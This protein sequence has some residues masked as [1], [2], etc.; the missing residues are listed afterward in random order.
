MTTFNDVLNA[1]RAQ[2]RTTREQG[3]L[4]E[5]LMVAI[6]PQMPD[7]GF[8]SVWTWKDWPDREATTGMNAQDIG[9]D[10][11]GKRRDESGYC[12]IQCKFYDPE[13]QIR[14]EDLGT[15]FTMSGK[16]AFS[17]RMIVATS[18][19]WTK[20]AE[21]AIRHQEPPVSRMRF[22]DLEGLAIDW[23][24]FEPKLTTINIEKYPLKARQKEALEAVIEGFK[25]K[26][27]GKLIMAC[28]T[29][30]TLTSL[31]IAETMIAEAMIESSGHVLFLVPSISLLAQSLHEWSFQR[32]MDHRYIAVCSDTRVDKTSEDSAIEDLI[33]PPSTKAA[34]VA[35]ALSQKANRMTVVFCT[36]QSI[37]VIHRAQK[38]G[39]PDFDLVICDEAHRT[40]GIDRGNFE[41][42]KTSPFVR[43]H[44]ADYLKA[45][46]RLYM[47][48]TP[49]IY[50]DHS[51]QKAS[52]NSVGIYS[53]D[54][55]A[56][57]GPVFYRLSFSDAI[58]EG[59]LSDY[60]VVVL[61]MSEEHV[62]RDMQEIMSRENELTVDDV[63]K[64]VGCYNAL[65][66]RPEETDS[67]K[68]KRVVSFSNTI[69][70]SKRIR[71]YFRTVVDALDEKENDGFTCQT[72]HV[73][74]KNTALERKQKLDWLR[75]P[76]GANEHGE[77]CRILSNARCLTE[78]VDVPSLD[79]AI[80]MNPRKSQVDVVQ[81]VG[82][83]MRKAEGKD[84]GYV[85]LPIVIKAGMTPEDALD[86]NETYAVVWEIL[87]AL[88]SHDDRLPNLI[89]K[90][91]LNMN[92]P[93]FLQVIGGN[94]WDAGDT[95]KV[96]RE[97]QLQLHFDDELRNAIYAKIV[98]KVGDRQ[99][100]ET[101]AKDVARI[102]DLLVQRITDLVAAHVLLAEVLADF[103]A[104]LHA[105]VNE[106]ITKED[107]ISMI[108]Q[109]IITEPI[110]DALFDRHSFS[111]YHGMAS[112]LGHIIS[113]FDEY[114]LTNE[115][116]SMERFYQSV[117]QNVSGIDNPA[118]R[119]KV[120]IELYE[121]FFKT[122]FP[123]ESESLGI[124]YTP[125]EIVDFILHSANHVLK[126][127][128]GCGIGDENVHVIDPFTGTGTFVNRLISNPDLIP[129][130]RL[131][132]KYAHEIHANEVLLMAYYIASVNIEMAYHARLCDMDADDGYTSFPGIV[133][134][135][136]FQLYERKAT[137]QDDI[138]D[139]FMIENNDRRIRQL[140][141][142]IRVIVGNPPY[143]AG[144]K[145]ENDA[146]K[147]LSY[148]NLDD[149]IR[150]TY[151]A[152]STSTLKNALYDSYIRAFKWASNRIGDEG[153]IAF[154]SGAAWI[155]RVFADGM[156]ACLA[157]EFSAIHVLHLRG[158]I[159]KNML[160]KGLAK[161]GQNVFGQ[162]SMT[163]IAITI[164]V[165]KPDATSRGK[166]F[167]HDIGDDLRRDEKLARIAAAQSIADLDWTAI[168]PDVHG[169]WLNQRNPAFQGFMALGRDEVKR[170]KV[171]SPDTV[172]R[173]YSG[174][175][176]T[177]R[178]A[179]AYNF[180][181]AKVADK[182]AAMI[183]FY[184]Q[185][186]AA[187]HAAK[188]TTPAI[189]ID[190]FI[191]SDST[192]ISWDG[193]LKSDLTKGHVGI[194]QEDKIISSIYRP[195]FKAPLY[196]DRQ[197]NNSVY[198][199]PSIFPTVD[200]QNR[201][202]AVTGV[203]SRSG[204]S[205][206]MTDYLPCSDFV[207]KSQ[208]FP[209]WIFDE[210]GDNRQDNIPAEAVYRFQDHYDDC[211]ITADRLFD[212]FYGV[213]HA[214]DYRAK[215]TNDLVKELPR[216]PFARDFWTFAD[217]GSQLANL[218]LNYMTGPPAEMGI[219]LDGAAV[220]PDMI[221]EHHYQ[222]TKMRWLDR[223]DGRF[224][225]YNER[226][227]V[228]PIPPEALRYVVSGKSALDWVIDRYCV[229]IDK[230]SGIVN[231]V[232]D[233]I[234]EQGEPDALIKLI[235]RITWLSVQTVKIVDHLPPALGDG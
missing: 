97:V 90:L 131:V 223:G 204:F 98:E 32:R 149:S 107:A 181:R 141:A 37:D 218:H 53:M 105:D 152:R 94:A 68:L 224:I 200:T 117:R 144:Q 50:T 89:S 134:T 219:L 202:I 197:F 150:A 119:Q 228:G 139:R 128:F 140:E 201:V 185:Q 104:S 199:M 86:D 49:R 161:E 17:S 178:D 214:P 158:D 69:N 62:S 60:R 26:D 66:N 38:M 136:T 39:A 162:A 190:D 121:K 81:A 15:F 173:I 133:L 88:R 171:V 207:E 146:N 3:T 177:N 99:Y 151:A 221:E 187:F 163:G 40:T 227:S 195:F 20:H 101:W 172:F 130:D 103:L 191:D 4:F 28:G 231:D 14:A 118:A 206:L 120:V 27:R 42:G 83:V 169:D 13:T 47:T 213:L 70:N 188:A 100:W 55:E 135:D 29:G 198:R 182:M 52:D 56:E 72:D 216:I 211:S 229:K 44:D 85:I 87:R 222:V 43:V 226:L 189:K 21:T 35:S 41:K 79:A 65:R 138:V 57:Y 175:V 217:A 186:R 183:E 210:D 92:K 54:D 148:P 137:R 180:S 116:A 112:S 34:S 170:G 46:K 7:A 205:C 11:V 76:A 168:T 154:V 1:L 125:I 129:D 109:Q 93:N 24:L 167:F 9:I 31:H 91:D 166:V 18:D 36:Y 8:E 82:R 157:T 143:S 33:F 184:N 80:F 113:Y 5:D 209:R 77:I 73:D 102:H 145:S 106:T 114:G 132:H 126:T 159:R 225:R 30:K 19:K 58:S 71:D 196:F 165:K 179:W 22:A 6:L 12:A 176:K 84:Y 48:A 96:A 153:V 124:A 147:N 78:G 194:F 160:S 127:E 61:N 208:C 212:Y 235:R 192:K 155:D 108:A 174:G 64:I 45:A 51:K 95:E 59:L 193:T 2:A 220:F 75:E 142:P 110:F 23:N 215:F 122:A 203:G 25:T 230:A 63:A 234:A 74:G 111:Q 232:N 67:K 156:R 233:W 164:L 16:S 10:L 115:L 123:K